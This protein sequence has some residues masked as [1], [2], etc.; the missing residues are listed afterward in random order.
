MLRGSKPGERRGGRKQGTPNRR[1]ILRDKILA[2]GLAHPAASQRSFLVKLVKDRKLPADTRMA[3]AP[4]CFPPKRTRSSRAGRPRALGSKPPTLGQEQEALAT[5]GSAVASKGSQRLAEV[6][7]MR[8]WSSHALEAL[9][10]VVQDATADPR[11]RRKAALKIA[12]FLLPKTAKK[13]KVIPDEYGFLINPNLA[14]A[15]RDIKFERWAL[16]REPARKIPA[17]AEK[18]KKLQAR[19]DAIR[20]RLEMPWPTKYG[21][22]EADN[23]IDRLVA[24]SS[25]R[26][27]GTALTEAQQAEEAH[28]WARY[29]VFRASPEAIA[30]RRREALE[31]VDQR[32]RRY[33]SPA[34]SPAPPLSAKEQTQLNFLRLL[35][36]ETHRHLPDEFD[37]YSCHPFEHELPAP[38]G[39]FYPRHSKL[40]PAGVADDLL[41]KA[42]DRPPIPPSSRATRLRST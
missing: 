13:P 33:P 16:M 40:R 21:D 10:D 15:Y 28:L 12:E 25:L 3:V 6:P 26:G 8:D 4:K 42:G 17:I 9:F 14:S 37:V 20:R 38:N 11:A 2:I 35:Y 30:R 24:L 36:P 22:K 29:D 32:S 19:A 41:V 5:A 39:N 27:N 1:T 23:D 31:N 18:I 7:P 34:G